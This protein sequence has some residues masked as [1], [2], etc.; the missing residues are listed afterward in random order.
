M[1][2]VSLISTDTNHLDKRL[3][4]LYNKFI[5]LTFLEEN[6]PAWAEMAID[7]ETPEG[8]THD[9]Y[10]DCYESGTNN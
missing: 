9:S 6:G 8:W 5:I 1:S 7:P 2:R 10:L 3:W 4:R